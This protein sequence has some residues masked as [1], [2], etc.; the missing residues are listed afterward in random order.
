MTEGE[1]FM[2]HAA[3]WLDHHE[4]HIF[5]VD[6]ASFSETTVE[7]PRHVA[8]HQEARKHNHPDDAPRFFRKIIVA[9]APATEVLVLGPSTAKTHFADFVREH[10]REL[11]IVA[12]E[13][14]DHPTAKQLAAHVRRYFSAGDTPQWDMGE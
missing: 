3:V 14:V 2:R 1:A 9:L 5:H 4:A 11:R 7:S 12:T 13:S 10:T 6:P 8:R